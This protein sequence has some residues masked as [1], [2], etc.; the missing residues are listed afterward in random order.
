MGKMAL[1]LFVFVL[2]LACG[3]LSS[4]KKVDDVDEDDVIGIWEVKSWV[5]AD[6]IYKRCDMLGTITFSRTDFGSVMVV[7]AFQ[8]DGAPETAMGYAHLN[9]LPRINF[10]VGAFGLDAAFDGFIEDNRMLG[11]LGREWAGL[12]HYHDDEWWEAVKK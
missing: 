2:I 9:E 6:P 7:F 12:T 11:R 3:G 1:K 10:Y 5:S 8:R 4:C